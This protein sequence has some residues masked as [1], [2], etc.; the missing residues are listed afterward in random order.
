MA[1]SDGVTGTA[2]SAGSPAVET[3]PSTDGSASVASSKAS[4]DGLRAPA[5]PATTAAAASVQTQ[6][7]TEQINTRPLKRRQEE[8]EA[9]RKDRKSHKGGSAPSSVNGRSSRPA[10]PSSRPSSRSVTPALGSSVPR[11]APPSPS[12]TS[13]V[14]SD[15]PAFGLTPAQTQEITSANV[16][17]L[18]TTGASPTFT[19]TVDEDTETEDEE[20][21]EDWT[22]EAV[23]VDRDVE[24]TRLGSVRRF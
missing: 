11:S 21:D 16:L 13:S 2:S 3:T 7:L 10:T 22:Q 15:H 1:L 5:S 14:T 6:V 12:V 4:E 23:L 9:H 18:Q 17:G 20:S 24:L 19:M 8:L